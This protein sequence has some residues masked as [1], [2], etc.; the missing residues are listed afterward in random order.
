MN[1][2]S[3][4]I[5]EDFRQKI[6]A[7]IESFTE[8]VS[9]KLVIEKIRR[10]FG[11]RYT[12]QGLRKHELIADAYRVRKVLLAKQKEL[13]GSKKTHTATAKKILFLETENASLREENRRLLEKFVVWA[14]NAAGNNMTE[15]DLDEP[16][17]LYEKLT[18]VRQ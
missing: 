1:R 14:H 5:T 8:E 6:V 11:E 4:N 2:R 10:E 3:S 7:V 16:I 13:R 12:E 18:R 17:E 15:Q 9:W